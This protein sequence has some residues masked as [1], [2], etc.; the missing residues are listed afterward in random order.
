MKHVLLVFSDA[1]EGQEDEY[2]S[3]QNDIHIHDALK[4]NGV[5]AGQR[6]R[7]H[8]DQPAIGNDPPRPRYLCI[9]EVDSDDPH[10]AMQAMTDN[11]PNNYVSPAIAPGSVIA[12]Y[13][14]IADR[15]QSLTPTVEPEVAA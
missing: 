2:N 12:L 13:S 7:L 3:W 11:R 14:A 10:V 9:Y 8:D 4:A 6:F 1:V 15:V 5:V